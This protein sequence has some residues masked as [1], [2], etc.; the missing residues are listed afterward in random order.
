MGELLTEK[1]EHKK[2]KLYTKAKQSHKRKDWG[3]YNKLRKETPKH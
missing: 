3:E 2:I 1:N